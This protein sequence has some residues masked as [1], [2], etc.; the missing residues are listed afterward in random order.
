MLK[1]MPYLD[2][3]LLK[4]FTE[5]GLSTPGGLKFLVELSSL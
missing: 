1:G 5:L 3:K 2:T 4:V